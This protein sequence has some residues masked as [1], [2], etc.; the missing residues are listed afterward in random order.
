MPNVCVFIVT[1]DNSKFLVLA[2]MWNWFVRNAFMLIF[3]D[4]MSHYLAHIR[5]RWLYLSMSVGSTLWH[6]LRTCVLEGYR[7]EVSWNEFDWNISLCLQM[8]A[9]HRLD[10]SFD[11][12]KNSSKRWFFFPPELRN[13]VNFLFFTYSSGLTWSAHGCRLLVSVGLEAERES[14]TV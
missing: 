6:F 14:K 5:T 4:K 11:C 10:T 13:V 9:I 8:T 7:K 3:W 2:G 12:N 1:C